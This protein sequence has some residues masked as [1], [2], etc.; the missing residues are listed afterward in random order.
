MNKS[1][2]PIKVD[3]SIE[4]DALRQLTEEGRLTEFVDAFPALVAGH[5]KGNIVEQLAN[6]EGVK[7]QTAYE[8]EGW[9][10]GTVPP[11]PLPFLETVNLSLTKYGMREI[12]RGEIERMV[13]KR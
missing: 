5:L 13:G 12:M 8:I 11:G 2:T 1:K 3:I 6:P 4:P 9:E 7:L 10:Y